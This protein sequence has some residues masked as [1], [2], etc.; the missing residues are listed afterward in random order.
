[1]GRYIRGLTTWL[2]NHAGSFDLL[3]VDSIREEAM[4]AIGVAN[5]LG[6]KTIVR[7]QGWGEN[8][9]VAWW[10][11]GRSARRCAT[12]ARKADAVISNGSSCE[13]A[14]VIHGFEPARIERITPGFLPLPARTAERRRD[15]RCSLATANGDLFAEPDAPVLLCNARLTRVGGVDLLVRAA[16]PLLSRYPKLRLW[17]I[18]D[19]PYRESMYQHL[20][21][22]GVRAS[23]AMPGSFSDSE[24]LFAAAD[25]YLQSGEDGL[26][27]FLPMAVSAA[28]PIVS[29]DEPSVRSLIDGCL[30]RDSE[31]GLGE[32]SGIHPSA[33]SAM[34]PSDLVEWC[35]SP[36]PKGVRIGV[37]NVLDNLDLAR[38]RAGQLRRMLIRMRPQREVTEA[39]VRLIERLARRLPPRQ[40][41][42]ESEAVS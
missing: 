5:A 18:G 24:D 6:L 34:R 27:Y 8:S 12:A 19:G 16:H 1:M 23:I 15:A 11:T 2:G 32:S 26:D 4:A 3:L 9:D 14:L 33:A 37:S 17:F 30:L 38:E 41:N 7:C 31:H 22:E 25:L 39:Y 20:R 21:S 40:V 10:E 35:V 29:V 28:L 36:T 42:Q 13:R